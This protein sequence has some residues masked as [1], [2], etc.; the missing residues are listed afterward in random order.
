MASANRDNI[1]GQI[2]GNLMADLICHGYRLEQAV[3]NDARDYHS[4]VIEQVRADLRRYG[5]SA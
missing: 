4:Q 2:V 1:E 5:V 3:T